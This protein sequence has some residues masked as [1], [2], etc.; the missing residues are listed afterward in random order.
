MAMDQTARTRA[1]LIFVS[2]LI[3]VWA[4]A[5][6]PPHG[7]TLANKVVCMFIGSFMMLA[8]FILVFVATKPPDDT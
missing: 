2:G 1:I 4:G 8:G 5:F 6:I 7:D 3:V